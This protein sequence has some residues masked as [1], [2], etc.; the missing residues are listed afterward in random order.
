MATKSPIR[1]SSPR[2]MLWVATTVAPVL[3]KT[4][5]PSTRYP[6]LAAPTSIGTVLHRKNR[7]PQEIEPKV[8]ST[9]FRPSTVT[10][11]ERAPAHRN[12]AVAQRLEGTSRTLST[13][14]ISLQI[15]KSTRS[16]PTPSIALETFLEMFTTTVAENETPSQSS[17]SAHIMLKPLPSRSPDLDPGERLCSA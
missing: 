5:S 17:T 11:A 3:I 10:T 4:R 7:R 14:Y 13:D 16:S 12:M 9:G 2:T 1:Q 6:P 15:A 8:T